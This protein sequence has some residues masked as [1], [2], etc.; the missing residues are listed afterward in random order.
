MIVFEIFSVKVDN[1]VVTC[2]CC[3]RFCFFVFYFQFIIALQVFNEVNST[4]DKRSFRQCID[5]IVK[6]LTDEDAFDSLIDFLTKSV[7]VSPGVFY[8]RMFNTLLLV[9]IM[10]CPFRSLISAVF[11]RAQA[12]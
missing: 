1:H 4:L 3:F 2:F 8:M 11:R 5:T 12:W 9:I 7:E 6:L 10:F